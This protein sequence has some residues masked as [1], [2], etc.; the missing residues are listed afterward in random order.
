MSEGQKYDLEGQGGIQIWTNLPEGTTLIAFSLTEA[1]P[2][3]IKPIRSI[4][5]EFGR[6]FES[7]VQPALKGLLH[8]GKFVGRDCSF[9]DQAPTVERER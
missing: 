3:A 4:G 5:L 7:I 2:R 8:C 6:A 1:S 9:I